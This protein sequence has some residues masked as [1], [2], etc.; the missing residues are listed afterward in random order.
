MNALMYSLAAVAHNLRLLESRKRQDQIE[1]R[2]ATQAASRP[3]RKRSRRHEE[4]PPMPPPT[5]DG[6][7]CLAKALL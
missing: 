3:G 5:D 1:A 6:R 2:R 7:A 4:Q